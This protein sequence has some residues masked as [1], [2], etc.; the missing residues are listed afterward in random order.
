MVKNKDTFGYFVDQELANEA[1]RLRR[2]GKFLDEKMGLLPEQI[3]IS[4]NGMRVLDVGCGSAG[5]A[6]ALAARYHGHIHITGID[7][8]E[9]ML[10]AAKARAIADH[11]QNETTYLWM[12]ATIPLDFPDM[13]FDLINARLIY[14]FQGRETW[15]LF[16]HECARLLKP[17]GYLILTEGDGQCWTTSTALAT[18]YA[19]ANE[20]LFKHGN[21]FYPE[22]AGVIVNLPN[23]LLQA[24]LILLSE[25]LFKINVGHRDQEGY[26]VGK[27]DHFSILRDVVPF[28]LRQGISTQERLNHLYQ[29]MIQEYQDP[30]FDAYWIFSR[31]VSQKPLH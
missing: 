2:Q 13:S 25:E 5:W 16:L 30:M 24:R 8:S 10:R 7:V 17:G 9:N 3:H 26:K 21:T 27:E 15:P 29:Q 6:S 11:I 12:D 22:Y 19:Y 20:A 4:E 23:L 28:I 18:L 14:G 31:M 1:S